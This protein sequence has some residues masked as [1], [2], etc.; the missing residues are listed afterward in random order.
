MSGASLV[1]YSDVLVMDIECKRRLADEVRE[2]R[3]SP[4][5]NST[6]MLIVNERS[7]CCP[8]LAYSMH[9]PLLTLTTV[10]WEDDS[11]YACMV[12][13]DDTFSPVL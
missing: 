12:S 10:N 5:P 11:Q 8:P 1:V 9:D 7:V 13:L 4:L 6:V 3:D 2:M